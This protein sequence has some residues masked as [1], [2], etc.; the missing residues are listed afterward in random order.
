MFYSGSTM[1]WLNTCIISFNHL[2]PPRRQYVSLCHSCQKRLK[3]GKVKLIANS[4]EPN[5]Q[6]DPRVAHLVK[7]TTVNSQPM[8]AEQAIPNLSASNGITCYFP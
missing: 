2:K 7:G 4:Y 5:K 3:L 8:A 6:S 1:N